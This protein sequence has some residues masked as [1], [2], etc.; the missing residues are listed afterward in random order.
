MDWNEAAPLAQP[1]RRQVFISEQCV[2]EDMEWDGL[3][4]TAVHALAFNDSGQAVGYARL[5]PSMQI[6][7]MAVVREYRGQGI[8]TALMLAL[9]ETARSLHYDHLLLH[10]QVHALS[11]YERQGYQC[12]GEPFDEAGIPHMMMSKLLTG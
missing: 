2:P 5:L 4:D 7:R 10:A 1:V 9:E 6:G 12:Q 11:F 8:G 3:D